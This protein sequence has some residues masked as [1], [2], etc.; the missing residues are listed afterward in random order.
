MPLRKSKK[1]ECEKCPNHSKELGRLNRVA[2]QL[3]GAKK[4]IQEQRYCPEILAVLRAVRAAV[5]AV[6]INIL[7]A[8]LKSCVANSL[9]SE[10]EKNKKI[11]EMA[12]L[13][14]SFCD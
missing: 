14:G 6:E 4:M 13:L 1:C 12:E 5:K 10:E 3:E 9:T 11:A 2:G 7:K 8:H